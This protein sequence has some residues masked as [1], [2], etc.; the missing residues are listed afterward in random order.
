MQFSLSILTKWEMKDG[1]GEMK[2]GKWEMGND[3]MGNEIWKWEMRIGKWK[4]VNGKWEMEIS[5]LE[6]VCGAGPPATLMGW[7]SLTAICTAAGAV[8]SQVRGS[9][10]S[11][12]AICTAAGAVD[13]Q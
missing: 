5:R 11:R 1:K 2:N 12:T 9:G 3:K 13:S 4:M 10:P 7:L 6:L 8:D